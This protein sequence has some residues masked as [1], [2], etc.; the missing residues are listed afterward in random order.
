[1]SGGAALGAPASA[2][3]WEYQKLILWLQCSCALPGI[4]VASGMLVHYVTS[5]LM[6]NGKCV[7]CGACEIR[8]HCVSA[9]WRGRASYCYRDGW[10]RLQVQLLLLYVFLRNKTDNWKQ[11]GATHQAQH[12]CASK[13]HIQ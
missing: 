10:V 6:K 12:T 8:I 7:C 4:M 9:T 11:R 2:A 13:G 5:H 1:V 3:C